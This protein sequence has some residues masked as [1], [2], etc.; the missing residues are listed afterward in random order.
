MVIVVD[1]SEIDHVPENLE[2]FFQRFPSI[3]EANEALTGQE[4]VTMW[5][6]QVLFIKQ[7]QQATSDYRENPKVRWLGSH[8]AMTCHIVVMRHRQSGVVSLG[9]F[10]NF[11]CWQFG[12]DGSAH[13]DGL[14]IMI[15]EITE[16]S[17]GNADSIEV[18]VVGGY[19]DARGD[20]ARN[21]LSL[22]HSLHQHPCW[23]LLS[24]FCVGKYNTKVDAEEGANVAILKASQVTFILRI[25]LSENRRYHS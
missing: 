2:D 16:L 7:R 22:L 10:D 14:D 19:T 20:A 1:G 11:C 12:E 15:Q 13:R 21:S 8:A 17:C 18:G 23:L 4:H 5:R 9:H 25:L 24:Y 6:D 3:G